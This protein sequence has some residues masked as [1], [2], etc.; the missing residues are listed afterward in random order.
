MFFAA[1]THLDLRFW[2]I[3]LVQFWFE[4]STIIKTPFL[5]V[6]RES[7]GKF[8]ILEFKKCR[9][10]QNSTILDFAKAERFLFGLAQKKRWK[11]IYTNTRLCRANRKIIAIFF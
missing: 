1:G 6:Q 4:I 3:N 9:F 7:R 11:S 10:F 8:T 5:R 2:L